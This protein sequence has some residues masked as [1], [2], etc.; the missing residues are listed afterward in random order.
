MDSLTGTKESIKAP[1]LWFMQRA[2]LLHQFGRVVEGQS[3]CNN[4][5]E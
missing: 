4:D 1:K 3:P 5:F 2:E